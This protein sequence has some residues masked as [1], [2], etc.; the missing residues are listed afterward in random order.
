MADYTGIL[1]MVITMLSSDGC[2]WVRRTM[3]VLLF[4]FGAVETAEVVLH[5]VSRETFMTAKLRF[6]R[7]SDCFPRPVRK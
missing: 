3:K 4:S 1:M 6:V 7:D 2:Q 5:E